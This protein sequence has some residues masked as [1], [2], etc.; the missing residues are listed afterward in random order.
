MIRR[1]NPYRVFILQVRADKLLTS[2]LREIVGEIPRPIVEMIEQGLRDGNDGGELDGWG[3]WQEW[4]EFENDMRMKELAEHLRGNFSSYMASP[5]KAQR[6]NLL[7]LATLILE[8]I[9]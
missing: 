3:K 4:D 7:E 9:E 5:G 8:G 2:Q 1:N 6:E